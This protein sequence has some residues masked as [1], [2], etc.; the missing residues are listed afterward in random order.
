MF[1]RTFYANTVEF[2][3]K[4]VT[5]MTEFAAYETAFPR[6]SCRSATGF[7]FDSALHL[8]I[9]NARGGAAW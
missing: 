4:I 5:L 3:E 2:M 7:E 9:M 6:L 8:A 1:C